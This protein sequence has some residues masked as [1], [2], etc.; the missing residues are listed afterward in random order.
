M[1]LINEIA[2]G[3]IYPECSRNTQSTCTLDKDNKEHRI[4]GP[5]SILKFKCN[6]DIDFSKHNSAKYNNLYLYGI[7]AIESGVDDTTKNVTLIIDSISFYGIYGCMHNHIH[8]T[9]DSINE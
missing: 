2:I 1:L 6:K 5:K 4:F 8:G 7:K 9:N 3:N